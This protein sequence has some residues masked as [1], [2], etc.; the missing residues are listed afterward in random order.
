MVYVPRLAGDPKSIHTGH[1]SHYT[2]YTIDFLSI[3]GYVHWIGMVSL[4]MCGVDD[5]DRHK[6]L[7][8]RSA[9]TEA[10]MLSQINTHKPDV[11]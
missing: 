6:P 2:V 10:G 8:N 11:L 5:N 3:G 1:K 4:H 9:C 7:C